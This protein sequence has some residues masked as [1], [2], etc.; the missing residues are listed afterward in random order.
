MPKETRLVDTINR[1]SGARPRKP[2][3]QSLTMV[4]FRD[5]DHKPWPDLLVCGQHGDSVPGGRGPHPG[6]SNHLTLRVINRQLLTRPDSL[7]HPQTKMDLEIS[8]L[9]DNPVDLGPALLGPQP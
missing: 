8:V 4:K 2:L 1:E 9:P 5:H 7:L 6:E 3:L